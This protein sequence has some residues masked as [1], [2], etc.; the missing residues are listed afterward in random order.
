MERSSSLLLTLAQPHWFVPLFVALWLV[1]SAVL[2]RVAGWRSLGRQFAASTVPSGQSF[3][4]VSGSFGSAHWP[5][6]YRNC[7]RIVVGES[8]LYAAVMFPFG[9]QSPA[10]FLPWATVE[11]V[12]EKQ[13]FAN[14]AVT[15]RLRGHWPVVT[16]LGPVGQL[17]KAAYE[18][19]AGS[20]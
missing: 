7:L 19:S 17:A 2:A 16:L 3:R 8:G 11:S 15:F 4:F 5:I 20:Q 12:T 13:L 9:F 1:A 14:R 6:R 18:A 10:L